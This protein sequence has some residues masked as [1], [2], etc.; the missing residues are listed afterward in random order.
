[1]SDKINWLKSLEEGSHF[2]LI[3]QLLVRT[4]AAS[5]AYLTLGLFICGVYLLRR[6]LGMDSGILGH[7]FSILE[8]FVFIADSILFM[9]FLIY[10][11]VA[12]FLTILHESETLRTS[13]K[14]E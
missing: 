8:T 14:T 1:M 11:F 5:I 9:S 6:Y 10:M 3:Y 13:K 2:R 4:L 12:A 7:L